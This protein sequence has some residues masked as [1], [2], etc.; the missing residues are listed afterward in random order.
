MNKQPIFSPLLKEPLLHFLLIGL[1]LFLLFAQLNSE[2]DTQ[3]KQEIM[4]TQANIAL[5]YSTFREENAKEPTDEELKELLR[6]NIKE[7]V[8]YH[9]AMA[10]GL[11]KEDKVIKHRLAEKMKYLFEDVSMADDPSQEMLKAY[12]KENPKKFTKPYA[13][14]KIELKQAFIAQ[15]QQKE[16]DAFYENLKNRYEITMSDDVRKVLNIPTKKIAKED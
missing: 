8:L 7:E 6:T 15:E 16:N 3:S 14:I 9:E 13:E 4:I 2:E 12:L 11:Y 5:I 1:G 10:I